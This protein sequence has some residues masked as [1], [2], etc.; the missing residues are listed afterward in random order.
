MPGISGAIRMP[1]GTP[2]SFIFRTPS[3]RARGEGVCG[4]VSRH[5]RSSSVGTEKKTVTPG[6]AARSCRMS[7]SRTASGDLVTSE[8]GVSKSSSACQISGISL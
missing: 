3:R 8:Q 4:S 2:A 1:L 5:A 7:M 6:P